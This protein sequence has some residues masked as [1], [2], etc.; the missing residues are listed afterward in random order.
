MATEFHPDYP[1]DRL[2]PF[3][4]NP[5]NVDVDG[6]ARLVGSLKRYGLVKPLIADR[7]DYVLAGNQ[8]LWALDADT[9]PVFK[10]THQ[11]KDPVAFVQEHNLLYNRFA[12][13]P[14]VSVPPRQPHTWHWAEPEIEQFDWAN[15]APLREALEHWQ[16]VVAQVGPVGSIVALP[17]GTV[18]EGHLWAMLCGLSG[19]KSLIRYVSE[20]PG[21]AFDCIG[22]F[23][24]EFD[25]RAGRHTVV[26]HKRLSPLYRRV[27]AQW[28]HP[29]R[30]VLDIGCGYGR[31]F[32]LLPGWVQPYGYEPWQTLPNESDAYNVG[33]VGRQVERIA[34]TLRADGLF[35]HIVCD[36]VLFV[37]QRAELTR[38]II[39]SMSSM[40]DPEGT[41][42]ASVRVYRS[43]DRGDSKGNWIGGRAG[44]QYRMANWTREQ[45]QA[46]F[47][48]CFTDVYISREINW[49]VRARG[50][51]VRDMEAVETEFNLPYPQDT[52]HGVVG[53]LTESLEVA[54]ARNASP[55]TTA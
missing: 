32:E 17:D 23:D 37:T 2:K 27:L 24:V 5:R 26:R 48:E 1:V 15:H 46:M 9:A 16:R 19:E 7:D 43:K 40:L 11:I 53:D 29:D 54:W 35:G 28:E 31:H 22:T 51:K 25:I 33:A 42:W 38:A 13:E 50:P 21:D 10:L 44:R 6:R 4:D 36:H 52:W 14:E 20:D 12:E 8:R 47:E 45:V 3:V 41:A 49:F 39:R 30:R 18:I 34:H 55:A